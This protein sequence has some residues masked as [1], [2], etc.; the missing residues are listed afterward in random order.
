[1]FIID[2]IKLV[3]AT[4]RQFSLKMSHTSSINKHTVTEMFIFSFRT[5]RRTL[6]IKWFDFISYSKNPQN[7]EL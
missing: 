5:Y 6:Y 3:E 7:H 2:S 4:S 1:M